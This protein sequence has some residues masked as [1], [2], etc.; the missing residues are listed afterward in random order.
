MHGD[1]LIFKREARPICSANRRLYPAEVANRPPKPKVPFIQGL[2]RIFCFLVHHTF[3]TNSAG[4]CRRTR[5]AH[6]RR[7]FHI[8]VAPGFSDIR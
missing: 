4:Q 2:S 3:L 8:V 1:W 7:L 6:L 5:A